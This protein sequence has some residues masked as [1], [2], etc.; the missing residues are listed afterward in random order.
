MACVA[1]SAVLLAVIVLPG[2]TLAQ[3][4]PR[5][6]K[7]GLWKLTLRVQNPP[8]V[9]S[10]IPGAAGIQNGQVCIA[11]PLKPEDILQGRRTPPKANCTTVRDEQT[12]DGRVRETTCVSQGHTFHSVVTTKE[13]ETHIEGT[14]VMDADIDPARG[15]KETFVQTLDWVG[16]CPAGMK[17]NEIQLQPSP[18]AGPP[19]AIAAT[20]P[21]SW[22]NLAD[23]A[24][25]NRANAD[26]VDP[27]RAPSI[28]ARI[29]DR[30][31]AYATAA[32]REFLQH[33]KQPYGRAEQVV[34]ERIAQRAQNFSGQSRLAIAKFVYACPQLGD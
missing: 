5:Q 32:I 11:G 26:I 20:S 12:S 19:A 33:T 7:P 15:S 3:Q 31:D 9:D 13:T 16:N 25:A 27:A 8:D 24:A 17:T 1:R 34:N 18:L 4:A 10:L 22:Q 21:P 30:A 6:L 28:K 29:S 14:A 23:C 2:V